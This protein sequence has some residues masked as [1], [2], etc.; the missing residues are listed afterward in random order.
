[1][2]FE[3]SLGEAI[4]KLNILELKIKKIKDTERLIEIEKE[5]NALSSIN[6]YKNNH[7]YK[8]LSYVNEQ[9]WDLTNIIKE[10]PTNYSEI[11][12]LIFDFNE[13][14]F[15]IKKIFNTFSNLKEQKSYNC[16][17]CKIITENINIFDKIPEI[18]W[19]SIDYDYVIFDRDLRNIFNTSNFIHIDESIQY[20]KI[21]FNWEFYLNFN[22]DL[23]PAGLNTEKDALNHWEWCGKKE[24]RYCNIK[25]EKCSIENFTLIDNLNVIQLLPELKNLFQFENISYCCGGLLGDFIQCLSVINENYL[26]TG[27]KGDLFLQNGSENPGDTIQGHAFRKGVKYT[28]DDT[29]EV[30]S[31]Q[32]YINSYKIMTNEHIDINLNGWRSAPICENWYKNYKKYYNIEW[33]THQ[34]L[35]LPNE[36]KWNNRI[37]INTTDYSFPE[38]IDFNILFNKHG[39]DLLF[40]ATTELHYNYFVQQTGL[41]IELYIAETFTE[42]CDVINSCKCIYGSYSA[43]LAIAGAF[44]KE[45]FPPLI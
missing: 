13:K 24:G 27:K 23:R 31:Q 40:I 19:I 16:K 4:D 44:H 3:L 20:S 45:R 9:I 28:Y 15:R 35:T 21:D 41:N 36:P 42:L 17:Y 6:Y 14:R 29:Y 39:S 11:A 25:T 32:N 1:M 18:N 34:W 10:N 2:Y 38:N 22:K 12:K 37:L 43:P 26:K 8:I 33:G 7:Y 5:I 30:I